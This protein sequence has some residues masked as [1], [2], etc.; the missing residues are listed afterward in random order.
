MNTISSDHASTPFGLPDL[1]EIL[2]EPF[3]VVAVSLF[4]IVT[5]PFAVVSL[6]GVRV[7]DNVSGL[8]RANPLI[9][10]RGSA[11]NRNAA[12]ARGAS[13]GRA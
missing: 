4:W 7:W 9:L 1:Q 3:L 5:L 10:H 13:A 11:S 2:I 8:A 6:L 12:P